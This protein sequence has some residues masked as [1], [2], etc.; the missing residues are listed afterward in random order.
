MAPA[1]TIVL[2]TTFF[3]PCSSLTLAQIKGEGGERDQTS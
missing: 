3:C 2:P 1:H